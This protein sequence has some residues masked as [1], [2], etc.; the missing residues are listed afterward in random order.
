MQSLFA[1]WKTV[2]QKFQNAPQRLWLFD[3]DGT[4]A[5]IRSHPSN[6]RM[7]A[8]IKKLLRRLSRQP[9]CAVGIVSG[10][11]LKQIRQLVRIPQL[12]YAGNHGLELWDRRRFWSNPAARRRRPLLKLAWEVLWGELSR[13]PGAWIEDKGLSLSVHFRQVKPAFVKSVKQGVIKIMKTAPFHKTLEFFE[14]KKSFD[15]RPQV[16]WNKGTIVTSLSQ[17]MGKETLV[18][19]VGDDATDE[20]AFKAI[21]PHGISVT[22]GRNGHSHATYYLPRQ[23]DIQKLLEKLVSL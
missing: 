15:I 22:I 6:V 10:R 8:S 7:S 19:Y 1:H 21:R 18:L 9:Q 23:K 11:S 5:P 4:L 3:F 20:D 12:F 16:G 2:S 13:I 14:E 17:W